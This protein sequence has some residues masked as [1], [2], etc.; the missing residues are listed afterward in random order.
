VKEV[1]LEELM[2]LVVVVKLST[3]LLKMLNPVETGILDLWRKTLLSSTTPY[4]SYKCT[5]S[6]LSA[7]ISLERA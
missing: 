6:L 3:A 1:Y 7:N 5:K 4:V 2:D